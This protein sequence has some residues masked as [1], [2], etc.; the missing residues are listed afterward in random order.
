MCGTFNA[1][2]VTVVRMPAPSSSQAGGIDWGDAGIGAGGVIAMILLG[3][4][5]TFAVVHRRRRAGRD[6]H[7]RLTP[8]TRGQPRRTAG[9]SRT[10]KAV[11]RPVSSPDSR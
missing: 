3:L 7:P 11:S 6:R 2:D 1:P 9:L 8:R 5:S 4:G 10:L